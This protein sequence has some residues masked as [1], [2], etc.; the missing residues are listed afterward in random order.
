[1]TLPDKSGDFVITNGSDR[2][3]GNYY[4]GPYNVSE[5][6]R[7][8]IGGRLLT[9]LSI[10]KPGD[11]MQFVGVVTEQKDKSISALR[12]ENVTAKL[13]NT[14][15]QLVDSLNLTTDDFGRVNGVFVIP[16]G[17]PAR[18]V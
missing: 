10:Y 6:T 5:D 15:R 2:L 16:R 18:T 3:T 13:Y 9:D 1:V 17:G 12:N 14:N 11:R 4:A 8:I 7:T